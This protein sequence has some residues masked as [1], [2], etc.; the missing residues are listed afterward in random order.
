[1]TLL[2]F[3]G[4]GAVCYTWVLIAFLPKATNPFGAFGL[5]FVGYIIL[6]GYTSINA[7][8]KSELFPAKIRALGVGLGYGLANSCFGGTAPLIYEAFKEHDNVT[9][10]IVYVT[11]LTFI[12]TLIY[13]FGLKNKTATHLDH[14]QGHAWTHNDETPPPAA[15]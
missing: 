14:E 10:F 11:T 15:R 5:L 3:F 12:S 4:V 6:T 2:V 1:M 8:V 13:I 7:L 9:W